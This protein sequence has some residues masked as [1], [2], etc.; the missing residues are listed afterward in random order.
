VN[1]CPAQ[2]S[3]S[4]INTFP[5]I[6]RTLPVAST[7]YNIRDVAETDLENALLSKSK[8]IFASLGRSIPRNCLHGNLLLL[9]GLLGG[10]AIFEIRQ[11]VVE[12]G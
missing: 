12:D 1:G 8:L 5:E 2:V 10:I 7:N 3:L 4:A 6:L 11:H 9:I